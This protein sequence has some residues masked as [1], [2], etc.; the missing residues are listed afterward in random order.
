MASSPYAIR[1]DQALGA[2]TLPRAEDSI[3]I[4]LDPQGDKATIGSDGT[5]EVEMA[6]G[7]VVVDFDPRPEPDDDPDD[8]GAN[9]ADHLSESELSAIA[10]DLLEGIEEDNRSRQEWLD[11]R[12]QGI[13]LLGLKLEQPRSDAGNSAAP[14]EGMSTVRHPLLLEATIRFQANARGELLPASG[15]VKVLNTLDQTTAEDQR[16]EDL[17]NGMNFYLTSVA[18]EYYPDSDRMLFMVGFGGCG[19]KKVYNC[20]LRRRPVSE[21]VDASDIIVS[22]AATDLANAGRVTHVIRMRRSVMKRMQLAGAYR[23]VELAIDPQ[24]DVNAVDREKANV[25]G[26]EPTTQARPKDQDRTVYETYCEIDVPGYEHKDDG[27]TTG[28]PLPYRVAIDK[29][30]RKILEI[31]RNWRDGDPMYLAKPALVKYPFIPGLGFYDIGLVHTLGNATNA[32][33]AAWREMLDSGM[34]A[35]FPGFL[36]AKGAARQNT[37][38]IRIPPGAGVPIETQ[39][40][41]IGDAVMPLPYKDVGTGL[42][43]LTENIDAAGQRVGNIAEISVGEGRQDAPVGTTLALIEQATKIMDAVH[44]RLHAA[45]AEEFQLLKQC[46]RENPEAFVEAVSAAGKLDWNTDDFLAALDDADLV[47]M[48][49]PNTPSH[50]HRLMKAMAIKQLQSVNPQLYDARAVDDRVLHMIGVD[51]PESLFAPPAAPSGP[52]PEVMAK[53]ADAALKSKAIDQKAQQANQDAQ[54]R[55]ATAMQEAQVKGAQIQS[56]ERIAAL[57]LAKEMV[58]HGSEPHA[59]DVLGG[60]PPSPAEAGQTPQG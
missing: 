28:L 51:D 42:M 49:D 12:A 23:D 19:F 15:P 20:P 17:E 14:V 44:K 52:P 56:Q 25:Q 50:M 41:P 43:A 8:F 38:D 26:I 60:M 11:T 27:K 16:A 47:P 24:P 21:S 36:I 10:E 46:F 37:S 22:N 59:E 33:T 5:L 40:M 45:Q 34:Y 4:P 3:V 58:I 30:S 6:D 54:I 29:D 53:V 39:G 31:R 57:S 13:R 32:L 7:S 9:L 1:L 48:A 35:N 55:A 2:A 18:K